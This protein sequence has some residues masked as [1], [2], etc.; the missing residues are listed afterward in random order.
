MMALSGTAMTVN[1][2]VWRRLLWSRVSAR[3]FYLL[4]K[5]AVLYYL[6]PLP[7]L[8]MWYKDALKRFLQKSYMVEAQVPLTWRSYAIHAEEK[9]YVNIFAM[10]QL[11]AVI[12]WLAGV[13][14]LIG[15]RLAE[16][17]RTARRFAVYAEKKMTDRHREVITDLRARYGVRRRVA[18]YWGQDGEPTMTFGILKPV[19]ICSREPGSREAELLLCHEMVHIK[20]LDV[21]WKILLQFATFIHWW[22]PFLWGLSRYFERVCECSCDETAMA[23]REKDEVKS[24]LRLLV[25]EATVRRETKRTLPRWKAGFGENAQKIKERMDNLMMGK[26]WNRLAAGALVAALTFANSM[27][28]FAYRDTFHMEVAADTPQEEIERSLEVSDAEFIADKTAE[29]TTWEFKEAVELV[30]MEDPELCYEKQFTDEEG[31]I[32]PA[33]GDGDMAPYH[34]HDFVSGTYAEHTKFSNGGCEVRQYRAQRCTVCGYVIRGD[35]INTITYATC[36][37]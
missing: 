17:V 24:Y 30:E 14:F 31:N 10:I 8:K 28:V 37:H 11:A 6:I 9:L 32:Y 25:E 5:A 20:R 27:T 3:A 15:R 33:D 13:C 21:V 35:W 34:K 1:C 16:Y 2:L 4:A 26:K 22:N 7:F 19:I 23:G 29:E 36:P 12:V 18:L